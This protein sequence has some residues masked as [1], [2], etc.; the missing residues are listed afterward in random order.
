MTTQASQV[1]AIPP[2]PG[3]APEFTVDVDG[4]PED[5]QIKDDVLQIHVVLELDQMASFEISLNNWDD[6]LLRFKYSESE[7]SKELFRVSGSWRSSSATRTS[8]S[9]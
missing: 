4:Q 7:T 3:Y 8:S 9:R 6:K 2:D 1:V 5:V